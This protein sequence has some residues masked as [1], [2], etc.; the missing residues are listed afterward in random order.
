MK[1]FGSKILTLWVL[2]GIL[3]CIG[4][5]F[6]R[7]PTFLGE[8][9]AASLRSNRVDGEVMS[10]IFAE[11]L[12]Q[13]IEGFDDKGFFYAGVIQQPNYESEP[14]AASVLSAC[15]TSL[16]VTSFCLGSFC[17][18]SWCLG[19]ACLG[20]G[21]GGS[22]CVNSNCGNSGCVNSNCVG[23]ACVQSNCFESFCVRSN[24]I[25]SMCTESDCS[26][27]NCSQTGCSHCP[28][29]INPPPR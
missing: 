13:S 10:P 20:S 11:K 23:S 29:P 7:G 12:R 4:G 18:G 28:G 16:C 22:G 3:S 26:E 9:T 15:I 14:A 8:V 21:C 1:R 6:V 19:S 25:G 27:S 17:V 5:Y 2:V 24:C